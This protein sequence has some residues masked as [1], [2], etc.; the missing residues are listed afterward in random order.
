MND[1]ANL[2]RLPQLIGRAA[3][4]LRKAKTA[5]EILDAKDQANLAYTTAGAAARMA[6]AKGAHDQVVSACRKVMADALVIEAQ[7][8]CRLADE[9]DAAQERGEIAKQSSGRPKSVPNENTFTRTDDIGI[10][11]KQILEARIVRDAE[12]QKPGI[13]Q[14]TVDAQ[15][16]SKNGPTR[17]GVK[18]AVGEIVKPQQKPRA[19][20]TDPHE[21]TIIALSDSG[22]T[23]PQIADEVGIHPRVV[24]RLLQDEHIRREARKEPIIDPST[25]SMTAQQKLQTALQQMQKNFELTKEEIIRRAVVERCERLLNDVHLPKLAKEWAE[26]RRLLERRKGWMPRATFRKVLACLHP[27]RSASERMLS[28]A[29]DAF[30]K[31]EVVLVSEKEMATEDPTFPRTAA[32]L[33]K[34]RAEVRA[35]NSARGKAAHAARAMKQR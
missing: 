16:Q 27:D 29:F 35:R 14:Q 30:K 34:A 21:K 26:T 17:A 2:E 25:L 31:L 15:L 23:G 33:D 5:A 6:K 13:I 8:Q 11:R 18:R 22:M 4:A 12:K 32:E 19:K 1:I 7:A 9:Y 10:T 28:D 20:V 24:G 3:A